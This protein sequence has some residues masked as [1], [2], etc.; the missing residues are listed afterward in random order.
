MTMEQ[1]LRIFDEPIE[2]RKL[3]SGE[4]IIEGYAVVFNSESRDLGGFTEVILPEAFRNTDMSDVLALYNHDHNFVLGRTPTTLTLN[5]DNR[6]VK[7]TIKPPDTT[8]ANDLKQSIQRGD[9][10]GSSF[11]FVISK[12]G[13]SWDKPNEKGGL[14]KRAIKAIRRLVDVSPVTSPAYVETNTAYAKR[15]LGILKDEVELEESLEIQKQKDLAQIEEDRR[16]IQLARMKTQ[17]AF[18]NDNFD[19]KIVR[20]EEKKRKALEAQ[21]RRLKRELNTY[22]DKSLK[23]ENNED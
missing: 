22:Y 3:D 20:E 5:I 16:A 21:N 13:D 15:S 8:F 18:H 1:E 17:L 10:R 6:G 11:G 9:V 7:Y 2:V 14:Y 4:E 23:E 12:D 19:E